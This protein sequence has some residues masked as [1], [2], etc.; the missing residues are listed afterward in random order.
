MRRRRAVGPAVPVLV[1]V[2]VAVGCTA[3]PP[4]VPGESTAGTGRAGSAWSG[5]HAC[6]TAAPANHRCGELT[7][8]VDHARPDGR[9]LRLT[10]TAAGNLAAERT[11]LFLTGGPGQPGVRFAPAILESL[12]R[13]TPSYRVVLLDQRG[14][15]ATSLRCPRLQDQLGFSDLEVPTAEAVT[16]CAAALG[17]DRAHYATTDTVA[18]LEDLRRALQV[19]RWSIDG[20]SYG[21]YV[22]QRYAGAHPSAVDRLVLDSPVPVESFQATNVENFPEFADVLRRVCAARACPGDPGADLA[23]VVARHHL[24][25]VL[26]DVLSTMSVVDP[27]YRGMPELLHGAAGGDPGPLMGTLRGWQQGSSGP[28]DQLSQ[29]LHASTLCLDLGFPWGGAQAPPGTRAAAADRAVSDLTPAQLFP[30]D[31]ATARSNGE[32]VTCELWPP[33][34]D[35]PVP[36]DAL[37]LRGVEA[38]ILHGDRDLSTS[39]AWAR[40]TRS[41]LPGSRLVVVPGAGHAVQ[42]RGPESARQAVA[43]FLLRP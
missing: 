14:T 40:R 38:L 34:P 8:P 11:L 35:P 18:D 33:E 39:L 15:G 21:T 26:L 2:L 5:W 43:D 6:R 3:A 36:P 25:T 10:V 16:E 13:V 20:V 4:K 28:A 7:V 42:R 41:A 30:F 19:P 31:A 29:G 9:T 1:A 37:R 23:A 17:P 24:G 27:T 12:A 32:M 22:A